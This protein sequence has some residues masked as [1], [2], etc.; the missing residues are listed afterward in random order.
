M[1]DIAHNALFELHS[2][3][4][5]GGFIDTDYRSTNYIVAIGYPDLPAEND[6]RLYYCVVN[7]DTGVIEY[8]CAIL[9]Q[10][11]ANMRGLQSSFDEHCG[12]AP[13]TPMNGV[14]Q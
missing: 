12:A 11:V 14:Y 13:L 9:S 10:A 6:G 4:E 8:S 2:A 1:R 5:A 3:Y 7:V